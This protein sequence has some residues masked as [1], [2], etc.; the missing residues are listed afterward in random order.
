MRAWTFPG[1]RNPLWRVAGG[2]LVL[3]IV[4]VTGVF[5]GRGPRPLKPEAGDTLFLGKGTQGRF[6][7]FVEQLGAGR[8]ALS[9]ETIQGTQEEIRL[10]RV[11]GRLEEPL[12]VWGMVSPAAERIKGIW[13][14]MGPMTVDAQDTALK[15]PAGRGFMKEPGPALGWDHGVWTGL[16]TLVWDDLQGNGR[17]RWILPPG[18]H[19]GL[20]GQF[21]VDKGPV[22]WRAADPGALKNLTAQRMVAS[23]G[24]QDGKLEDV[25][26]ELE[27]GAVQA[28]L[29]RIQ[30]ADVIFDAPLAFQREDGWSGTAG[31]GLA[32][33]PAKGQPFDRMEFRD[34]KATRATESGPEILTALGARWTP[35]GLRLE[36]NVTWEQPLEGLKATLRAPR[37][38]QRTAPGPDLPAELQVGQ[39]WAEPQAV[40]T[41]GERSLS[42]P[43]IEGRHRQRTWR[44][45]APALGRGE[46]GTF[47]AGEGTGNPL[48]WQFKGPIQARFFDGAQ[49]R[50]DSLVWEGS[51]MTLSGRPVTWTRLRQRLTGLKV[52]KSRDQALFPQ[53]IAG[54][55]AAPEGDINL[56]AD[57]GQALGDRLTLDSRVEC[58]G[59]G[60]RLQAEHIS[61]TLGP[62]NVVKQMTA[63]GSVVLKGRMG[64]GRG[65]TL[66]LDPAKQV[67]V[68]HGNVTALTEVRP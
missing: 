27:G 42:S 9:Y 8:F 41:W 6:G 30:P 53:G 21:R 54:A 16:S 2:A 13:T 20:D 18:W 24:F 64:E 17:G 37:V 36:G 55:L 32:P 62:G 40:L 3:A 57:R 51:A 66:D 10:D 11:T 58:Q 34:F 65:D 15:A 7:T 23:L 5:M 4:G 61:V 49:V 60:W 56:R 1:T 12:T 26:A 63:N 31:H 33:R 68:W 67:A 45:H 47:S 50:C 25:A 28:S 35:A 38:L 22:D 44:I 43:R 29:V 59:Q 52:I 39:T 46:L 14:L 19:R 48:K